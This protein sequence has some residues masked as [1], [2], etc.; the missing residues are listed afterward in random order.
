MANKDL[1]L[2]AME[3]SVTL[4]LLER[5]L[6]S[7]GYDLVTAKTVVGFEKALNDTIPTILLIAEDLEDKN[8]LD[9]SRATLERFPTMPIIFYA[10]THDPAKV[11]DAMRAGLS[12]YI[13]PPLKIDAIVRAV[14]HSQKHSHQMGDWVRREVKRTTA[15][16]ETRVNEMDTLVK[17]SHSIN[18]SLDLDSVLTSVVTAAVELTGSEEGSL[19][20]V[21]ETTHE[22]YMRAGKN[23]EEGYARTFRLPVSDS[24]AGQVI[25]TGELISFCKDSPDKI[26]TSYLVYSLIYVPLS[27]NGKV[28]GV[29]GVD[30]RMAKRP[31][32]NH[33][34]LL[35]K[36]LADF[37]VIAIQNAQLYTESQ[38]ERAKLQTTIANLQ[39]GVILLDNE[40]RILL[41]NP[42]AKKAFGLGLKDLTNMPVL[43][44]ITN[45]DFKS[46][47]TSITDNPL[48]LHEIAFEDGRVFS[49]QYSP[50]PNVGAVITIEDI[51]HFKMLDRLKSDFIHTI[52]HDLRSPL[53]SIIGY[54]DLLERVGTL[55]QQQK[56]FVGHVQSAP[57]TS[58]NW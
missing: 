43:E 11:L 44:A 15:S 12:D 1:V 18:A 32:T 52:S 35:M 3:G 51:S 57:A 22:L 2:L 50:I 46:L 17:L 19:L 16:L 28:T 56:D 42:V 5:A 24:M 6:R 25:E 10:S 29:L 45:N 34:E 8:G 58:L 47:L 40:K 4:D 53:T 38:H 33:H 55:N 23:Y 41:I 49:A 39:D 7:A 21:D 31:F 20:M 48:K 27:F 36:V 14:Q 13:F 9:L 26:K 54:I 37:A 30:N